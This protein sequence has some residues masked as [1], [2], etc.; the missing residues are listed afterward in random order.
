VDPSKTIGIALW[1]G[2]QRGGPNLATCYGAQPHVVVSPQRALR[3]MFLGAYARFS[4]LCREVDE[5]GLALLA[6]DESTGQAAGLVR[7]RARP[8]RHVAAIIGRH[9]ACDLF[10]DRHAALALRH[11]AVVLDPVTSY[12]RGEAN[13]RFR[14]LDLRTESGFSDEHCKS[15]RGLR[16]EGPAIMRIANHT[17]FVL[18]LG[19]ATDWPQR[20]ED[21]WDMLPERVYFDEMTSS[22]EG[23]VTSM[24]L[25]HETRRSFIYRT[26]GPRETGSV[27]VTR[28][29]IAGTLDVIGETRTGVLT[30]GEQALRDGI[31]LGRYARCDGA[32]LLED[33]SMSR[34]HAMLIAVDDRLLIIDTASRNGIWATGGPAQRVITIAGNT[35]INLGKH[36]RIRWR[37]AA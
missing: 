2:Q 10:L 12:Q 16:A 3:T 33:P 9:D 7:L 36:T 37:W 21:A 23:S 13:V 30:I 6:V 35:E 19:D 5:P 18:P 28:G 20:A 31:L 4:D 1:A 26:H 14:L 15:M 32:S 34:V 24:P 27:L 11:V 22:P 17:I 8:G 29:D 25:A